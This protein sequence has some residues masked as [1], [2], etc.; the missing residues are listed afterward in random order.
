MPK[1]LY[2]FPTH[3]VVVDVITPPPPPPPS[4]L[5]PLKTKA[6]KTKNLKLLTLEMLRNPANT[7]EFV[8]GHKNRVLK[9]SRKSRL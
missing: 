4:P 2:E 1:I 9:K 6:V 8:Q 7:S 5:P 3:E